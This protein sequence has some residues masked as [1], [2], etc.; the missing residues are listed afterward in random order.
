M[1][2]IKKPRARR[3]FVGAWLSTGLFGDNVCR[4]WSLGAVNDVKSYSLA[5]LQAFEA[6]RL[7]GR[8]VDENV[9]SSIFLDETKTL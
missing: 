4:S 6:L 7:D 1:A 8:M 3:G 9:F 5:F 2:E